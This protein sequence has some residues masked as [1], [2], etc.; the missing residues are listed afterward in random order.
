[1]DDRWYDSMRKFFSDRSARRTALLQFLQ[2]ADDG[3]AKARLFV[4]RLLMLEPTG[5]K[6]YYQWTFDRRVSVAAMVD[7]EL[8]QARRDFR[9]L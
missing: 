1:M 9:A 6:D 4:H 5:I 3:E 2:H 7:D 8:W